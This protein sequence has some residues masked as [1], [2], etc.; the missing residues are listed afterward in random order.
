MHFEPK[1]SRL[2][3]ILTKALGISRRTF[4]RWCAKGDVPGAY[5]TRDG[6]WRVRKPSKAVMLKLLKTPNYWKTRKG[7]ITELSSFLSGP[8]LRPEF[9]REL[10][11][12]GVHRLVRTTMMNGQARPDLF[13]WILAVRKYTTDTMKVAMAAHEISDFDRRDPNLKERDPEKYRLLYETPR[14]KFLRDYWRASKEPSAPLMVKARM[15]RLSQSKVN[16]KTLAREFGYDPRKLL[17]RFGEN[18][19]R[20]ACELGGDG[21][22]VSPLQPKIRRGTRAP[23]TA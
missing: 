13:W 3:G 10:K 1:M 16:R 7:R 12:L 23:K 11:R 22:V 6:H 20:E 8:E 18:A 2:P 21:R 19:V 17:K 14:D 5:R 9:K 15:L 4:R